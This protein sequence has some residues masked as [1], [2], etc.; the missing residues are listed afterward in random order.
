[1][2]NP[3]PP[4]QNHL[5][6]LTWN[7]RDLIAD[8][9]GTGIESLR[10][11]FETRRSA[12]TRDGDVFDLGP[13]YRAGLAVMRTL[14]DLLTQGRQPLKHS[15]P[16]RERT[17]EELHAIVFDFVRSECPKYFETDSEGA[18]LNPT[19][20]EVESAKPSKPKASR[21]ARPDA[22]RKR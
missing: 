17:Y 13:D 19:P 6:P 22:K 7:H 3:N 16:P 8:L 4:K 9:F 20:V 2:P 14:L 5:A 11:A 12:L 21:K 15:P 18:E 1:M 10:G